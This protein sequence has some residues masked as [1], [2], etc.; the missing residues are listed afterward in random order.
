VTHNDYEVIRGEDNQIIAP[1]DL[2][3]MVEPGMVLEISIF[4]RENTADEID[5][6]KCLRCG[7]INSDVC[8]WI[9]W[10]VHLNFCIRP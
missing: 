10:K 6:S 2:A 5:K 7:H 3:R 1:S 4:L 8:G 9:Q